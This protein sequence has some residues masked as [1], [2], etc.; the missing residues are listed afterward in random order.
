MQV[1]MQRGRRTIVAAA[2]AAVMLAVVAGT[3]WYTVEPAPAVKVRW[4]ADVTDVQRRSL[5]RRYRLVDPIASEGRTVT[6]NLLDAST[7][8]LE[9]LVGDPAVEDT[10][11]IDRQR[12]ML[13]PDFPYGTRWMWVGDRLPVLRTPGVVPA[14]VAAGALALV[15]AVAREVRRRRL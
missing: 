6:Y 10:G 8:N 5:E 3:Y 15:A 12:F 14:L 7:G 13:P 9:A 2:I 1:S 11:D 4:R